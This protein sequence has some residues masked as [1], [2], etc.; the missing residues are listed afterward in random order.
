MTWIHL[1]ALEV[2]IVMEIGGYTHLRSLLLLLLL[3]H[4][5]FLIWF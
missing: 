3:V 4:Y 2:S 1:S 5:L